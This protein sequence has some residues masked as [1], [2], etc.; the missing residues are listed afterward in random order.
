M[1]LIEPKKGCVVMGTF[2]GEPYESWDIRGLA[3]REGFRVRR[4]GAFPWDEFPGYH[5]ARTLGNI[6]SSQRGNFRGAAGAEGGKDGGSSAAEVERRG[7]KGETRAARLWVFE[8]DNGE[9]L[10]AP[11]KKRKRNAPAEFDTDSESEDEVKRQ[12]KKERQAK[13]DTRK[14]V[15]NARGGAEDKA[16]AESKQWFRAQVKKDKESKTKRAMYR[17]NDDSVGWI[18]GGVE[19][20]EARFRAEDDS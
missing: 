16:V 2:T 6:K 14:G 19:S 4:S 11:K 5:H 8:V 13:K 10:N 20:Q 7:W 1:G 3:R 9:V 17:D 15:K 12:A 18:D